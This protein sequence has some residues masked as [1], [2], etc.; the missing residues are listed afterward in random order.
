VA[1]PLGNATA[2]AVPRSGATHEV[3]SI[4]H[5]VCKTFITSIDGEIAMDPENPTTP[6]TDPVAVIARIVYEQMNVEPRRM[7]VAIDLAKQVLTDVRRTLIDQ[8]LRT[9]DGKPVL[10]EVAH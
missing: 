9:E 1:D 7:N 3:E 6:D 5:S 10:I 4:T 8:G 2:A